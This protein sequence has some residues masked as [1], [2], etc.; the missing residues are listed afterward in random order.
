MSVTIQLLGRPRVVPRSGEPYQCRSRKSWALLTYLLLS[1]R[2]PTRSQLASMLFA[3]AD[4]PVRALRWGLSEI[5]RALGDEGS[6]DGDPV[7]LQLPPGAVVDV[8][9]VG[10]GAWADAVALPGLGAELLE[11]MTVRG[12]ATFDSWLLSA[13]RHVAAASEAILHEAALGCMAGG[14]LDA[15]IGYAVRAAAMSPLD[16]NHQALLIRLYRLSG[17]DD[18]ATKQLVACT[19]LLDNE[20]GVAPGPA[21]A[22]AM[23]AKIYRRDEIVDESAIE[24]LVEAGVAAVSAGA[25]EAGAASLRTAVRLAD[26]AGA[27]Q[28]RLRSRLVLAETLIHSLRGLDQEGLG[29]L[30]EADGIAMAHDLPDLAAQA[31]AE[32]GYVDFL[33]A[34]YDRAEVWLT[35]SQ[36]LAPG[37]TSIRAKATAYLGSVDSDR[38]DYPRA[39]ARLNQA[40]TSAVEVNEPRRQAFALSMLGRVSLLRGDLDAAVQQLDSSIELAERDHWLSFLPWPQALRGEVQLARGDKVAAADLL[41]Q[42]FARACQLGDPCWEGVSARGLA[43][44][45]EATGEPE[46]AF[47]LLADARSRC[48]RMPDPYVW[49]DGYILDAQCTLGV[50]HGHAQVRIWVD[51]L[52]ELA[53]RAGMRELTIRSLLHGAALGVAVDYEAAARLAADVDNPALSILLAPYGGKHPD[54]QPMRPSPGEQKKKHAKNNSKSSSA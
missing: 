46:R 11:G 52:R 44:V 1:E 22:A 3:E 12:A 2:P 40:V 7:V 32:L 54:P 29:V 23:R 8:D 5:R 39:I 47:A 28:L 20:L 18:A 38:A 50:R 9:V 24:A 13:Q 45:A 43:L 4:D 27:T 53:S 48:N 37:S 26:N 17:D 21:V 31:R 14:A 49:L 6:V 30:F 35:D 10:R 34:R 33:R 19:K 25:I 15:A 16:E 51:S 36:A 42:A 41:Q